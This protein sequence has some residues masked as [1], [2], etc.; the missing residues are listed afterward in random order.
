VAGWGPRSDEI[1][2]RAL[3]RPAR[4]ARRVTAGPTRGAPLSAGTLAGRV[5]W[6]VVGP[7]DQHAG[8]YGLAATGVGSGT[9]RRAGPALRRQRS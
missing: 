8:R 2:C 3:H 5:G 4:S 6:G 7:L 1:K 9:G